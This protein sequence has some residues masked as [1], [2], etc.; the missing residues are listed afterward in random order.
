MQQRYASLID[1]GST[2]TKGVLVDLDETKII[3]TYRVPTTI[4]TGIQNGFYTILKVFQT[5]LTGQE[6]DTIVLVSSSAAGGLKVVVVGLSKT[7]SLKAATQISFNAGAKIAGSFYN[8]LTY[9][10]ID[11]I[12]SVNADIL[13][14]TGGIDGGEETDVQHNARMLIKLKTNPSIVYA[15][16]KKIAPRIA[17]ILGDSGKQCVLADNVLP[18]LNQMNMEPA[19]QAIADLFFEKIVFANGLE[20]VAN[21]AEK[22]VIPTPSAVLSASKLL[23]EGP[24][25][26]KGFGP[27]VIIDVGGATTDV[28]SVC[29][30]D[31]ENSESIYRGL[32]EPYLKRTVEGDIGLRSSAKTLLER[33]KEKRGFDSESLE[34]YVDF[35]TH[36]IEYLPK[37]LEHVDLDKKLAQIAIHHSFKRHCGRSQT[38]RTIEGELTIQQGK[39]L[40]AVQSIIATGG[41]FCNRSNVAITIL[42]EAYEAIHDPFML[43]PK[44]PDLLVDHDY[45]VSAMGLL[46]GIDE[47]CAYTLMRNSILSSPGAN[48]RGHLS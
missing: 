14:L 27:I 17:G 26:E 32:P 12:D 5:Q 15:G 20:E 40:S 42:K 43:K 21:I 13:L 8:K 28:C 38:I 44:S 6:N 39:N 10:D 36:S 3:S 45:I 4:S 7:L 41:I 29:H 11:E 35:V 2:F 1:I 22:K 34:A 33:D 23:S 19:K 31:T 16:N 46:A 18:E 30:V 24:G 9:E 47:V 25:N 48:I 37:S